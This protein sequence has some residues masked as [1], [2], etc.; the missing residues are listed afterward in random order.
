MNKYIMI[1]GMAFVLGACGNTI[2][3]IGKDITHAGTKVTKWQE[4]PS[5]VEHV[6]VKETPVV[7]ETSK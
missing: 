1:V 7:K 6:E 4:S 3:G 2:S 5:T